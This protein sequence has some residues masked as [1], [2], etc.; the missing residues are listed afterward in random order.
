MNNF[1]AQIAAAAI[2]NNKFP[3]ENRQS[4]PL[5]TPSPSL[6]FDHVAEL[7]QQSPQQVTFGNSPL[8]SRNIAAMKAENEELYR[9]GRRSVLYNS[10]E[11]SYPLDCR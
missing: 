11:S 10:F 6:D 8:T 5:R 7:Q 4:S 9:R 1:G 3:F 2:I